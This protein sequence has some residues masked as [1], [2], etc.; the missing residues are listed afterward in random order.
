MYVCV[1][2]YVYAGVR[3]CGCVGTYMQVYVC[4]GV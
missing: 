2:M 4:V 3:M 1:D